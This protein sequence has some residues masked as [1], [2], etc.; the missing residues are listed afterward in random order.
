VGQ[1]TPHEHLA[2]EMHEAAGLWVA[3]RHTI[4]ASCGKYTV[5]DEDAVC[6]RC[7]RALLS[8]VVEGFDFEEPS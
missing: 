3:K 7:S 2:N 8:D 4:C 6:R 5:T 1:V